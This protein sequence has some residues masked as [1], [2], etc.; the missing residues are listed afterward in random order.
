[1]PS[2]FT[3]ETLLAMQKQLAGIDLENSE[4]PS[5]GMTYKQAI[6]ELG[7]VGAHKVWKTFGLEKSK[8]LFLPLDLADVSTQST[9]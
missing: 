1:M 4:T 6:R 9:R 2:G 7:E 8:T 5:L 3:V